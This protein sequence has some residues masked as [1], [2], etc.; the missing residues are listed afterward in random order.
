MKT[1]LAFLLLGILFESCSSTIKTTSE[2]KAKLKNHKTIAILPFEVEFDLRKKN[3]KQFTDKELAEVRH[4]MAL[5]LQEHLYRWLISYNKKKPL[6][7]D[8]QNIEITDSI[9]SERKIRFIDLYNMSRVELAKMMDVDAVL[10]PNVIFAQP[11]SE[12]ASIAFMLGVGTFEGL[13]TQEM[14]MQVLIN[15]NSSDTPFWTF[16]TKTQSDGVTKPSKDRKKENI[17]YPLFRNIDQS[18]IK[19]IKKFPYK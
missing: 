11:N 3:Q 18:L 2:T 4:F 17:L 6:S 10:T 5:G 19:F 12:G 14:R 15:D 13:A 16:K 1:L 8:I 7:V 9:L